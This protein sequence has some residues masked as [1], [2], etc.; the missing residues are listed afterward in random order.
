MKKLQTLSK[1][2]IK[3][4]LNLFIFTA[5]MMITSVT[6]AALIYFITKLCRIN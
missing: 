2:L 5:V 6:I 3:F 1:N 4:L